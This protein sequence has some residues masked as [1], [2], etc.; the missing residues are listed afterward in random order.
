MRAPRRRDQPRLPARRPRG[1]V[2][3]HFVA[4]PQAVQRGGAADG[5]E[6][7]PRQTIVPAPNAGERTPPTSQG[8]PY[9]GFQRAVAT[10]DPVIA[11]AA[12]L[13][14]PRVGLADA[15]RLVLVY[16]R[17][18]DRRFERAAV[19]WVSVS[20][21]RSRPSVSAARRRRCRHSPRWPE[22]TSSRAP[23]RS[24]TCST[25]PPPTSSPPSSTTGHGAGAL[26][27]LHEQRSARRG[28]QLSL[29]PGRSHPAELTAAGAGSS[30]SE[31][32]RAEPEP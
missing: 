2:G 25:Q 22:A 13:E 24:L 16:H 28:R 30:V 1:R 10:D 18:G 5:F 31:G 19:R 27:G 26:V 3:A 12:A 32:P 15:L 23:R 6:V 9:A 4:R 11:T 17:V 8:H 21:R 20:V 7:L 14:L 29:A